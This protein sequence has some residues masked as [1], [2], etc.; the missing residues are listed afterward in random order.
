MSSGRSRRS[1]ATRSYPKGVARRA[2]ILEAALRVF[3]RRGKRQS[4]LTE[5]AAEAGL[6][7]TGLM[8]YFDSK[9]ELL[10][11]VLRERDVRAYAANNRPDAVLSLID[12]VRNNQGIPGLALLYVTLAIDAIDPE[13]EAHEFFMSHYA[14]LA[15]QIHTDLQQAQ[16]DGLVR[17]DVTADVL[18]RLMIAAADGL[19]LR[20][21]FDAGV[22]M[23][24]DLDILHQL[25]RAP[26]GTRPDGSVTA[27]Y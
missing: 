9:N 16:R 19:Q 12:A 6:S 1:S 27:Y 15:D 5:I 13:H 23:A 7:Q 17:T 26:A 18:A 20:Y 24:A 22:D 4:T 2:E 14:L 21:L 8:H 10:T 25:M 3:S 11:A